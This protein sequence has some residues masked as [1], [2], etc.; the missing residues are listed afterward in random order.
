MAHNPKL[1]RLSIFLLICAAGISALLFCG[2]AAMNSPKAGSVNQN[3]TVAI[4]D[5]GTVANQAEQ[6]YQAKQI[7]QTETVRNAINDLGAAYNE[8]RSAYLVLLTA[9]SVAQGTQ[10]QQLIAC[11]PSRSSTTK[12]PGSCDDYTQK[13]AAAQTQLNV[14][15][16]ALNEKVSAMV[17]KTNV[18]KAITQ[19]SSDW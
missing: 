14:S 15:Q 7:P 16:A 13:A 12:G 2:C 1:L 9:E 19:K 11:A 8:A 5:A 17:N 18:V 4:A 3:I 6:M 10:N